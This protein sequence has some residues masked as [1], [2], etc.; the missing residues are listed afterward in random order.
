MTNAD[1]SVK[2]EWSSECDWMMT[3][4][5]TLNCMH[6]MN[7]N[8]RLSKIRMQLHESHPEEWNVTPQILIEN[9]SCVGSMNHEKTNSLNILLTCVGG[10]KDNDQLLMRC[11]S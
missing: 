7:Q 5:N 6:S 8:I 9:W 1:G 11:S 10:I 3:E 4:W 2:H